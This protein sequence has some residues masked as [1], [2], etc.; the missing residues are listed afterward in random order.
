MISP[1]LCKEYF[2]RVLNFCNLLSS[3]K[4]CCMRPKFFLGI[5][6]L[7]PLSA[8]AQ[9]EALDSFTIWME[10]PRQYASYR[11]H[12]VY[13]YNTKN[14]LVLQEGVRGD[15]YATFKDFRVVSPEKPDY[16]IV[17]TYNDRDFLEWKEH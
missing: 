9:N 17:Y 5:L 16:R 15:R 8:L 2:F 12:T 3:C 10:Y 6:F 13:K 7:V 14:Q 11:M 4:R 1:A